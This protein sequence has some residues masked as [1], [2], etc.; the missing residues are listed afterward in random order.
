MGSP[1]RS[2]SYNKNGHPPGRP[3]ELENYVARHLEQGVREEEDGQGHVVLRWGEFEVHVHARDSGVSDVG[4]VH[5]GENVE[6]RE[7]RQQ[8]PVNF[9][10]EFLDLGIIVSWDLSGVVSI[11]TLVKG[12]SG[13]QTFD[14]S[15]SPCFSDGASCSGEEPFLLCS[16]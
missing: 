4:T 8:S 12:Y 9:G 3:H 16:R 14:A 6:D 15:S 11:S 10:P 1:Y 13:T 7:E 5:E 2:P